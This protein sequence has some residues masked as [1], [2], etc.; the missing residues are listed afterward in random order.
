LREYVRLQ[1]MGGGDGVAGSLGTWPAVPAP[2]RPLFRWAGSKKQLLPTLEGYWHGDYKRYVEPFAGSACLFFR[3]L[4]PEAILG[5]INQELILTYEAIRDAPAEVGR[6]LIAAEYDAHHYYVIR[7]QDPAT[8]DRIARAARFIYLNRLCFNGLYR[9]NARGDFNVPFGGAKAGSVP[10]AKTL[11]QYAS[12]ISRVTFR[13]GDFVD[14]LS[15]VRAGDFIYLDPPYAVETQWRRGL[16]YTQ[17]SFAVSDVERLRCFLAHADL[18]GASFILSYADSEEGHYLAR[19]F[20]CRTVTV[21]RTIAGSVFKR[22][23]ASEL[24]ITNRPHRELAPRV[25]A[26]RISRPSRD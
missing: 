11:G 2:L 12:A 14:T 8:L 25:E 10:T 19:P 20:Y 24:L 13:K 16:H 1:L 17:D 7:A 26:D 22:G 5:D 21:R 18:V 4:P 6:H 3:L 15:D 23:P 9:T